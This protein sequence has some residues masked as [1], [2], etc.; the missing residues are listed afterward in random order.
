[1]AQYY[2]VLKKAIGALSPSTSDARRGVYEK[3]R[4]ALVGQL[5]A[6][7]P[8]LSTSEI[9]RQ[10][11]ELEEAI[12]KVEREALAVPIQVVPSPP[13]PAPMDFEDE[14]PHTP[15]EEPVEIEEVEPV[16]PPGRMA[17]RSAAEEHDAFTVAP[18]RP[19][20]RDL[21]EDEGAVETPAEPPRVVLRQA[22]GFDQPGARAEQAAAAPRESR[23]ESAMNWRPLAEAAVPDADSPE[24]AEVV[25]E[26][27]VPTVLRPDRGR[28]QEHVEDA[29]VEAVHAERRRSRIPAIILSL[30]VIGTL[31]A[32]GYI[33]WSQGLIAD[34]IG[35]F[36]SDGGTPGVQVAATDPTKAEDRVTPGGVSPGQAPPANVRV[37]DP[38]APG[39]AAAPASPSGA[40]APQAAPAPEVDVALANP[41]SPPLAPN[42]AGATPPVAQRAM[43]IDEVPGGTPAVKTG[44]VTWSYA[45]AGPDGPT[46]TAEV[47]VPNANVKFRVLLHENTFTDLPANLLIE[48]QVEG[49]ANLPGGGIQAVLSPAMKGSP[50]SLGTPLRGGRDVA[51]TDNLFWVALLNDASFQTENLQLLGGQGWMDIPLVYASGGRAVLTLELGPP[52]EG[53]VDQAIVAWAQ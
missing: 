38:V 1:M 49:S 42:P 47:S 21:V 50:Q 3:A 19:Y 20:E 51:V 44:T 11:L 30:F 28:H 26:E 24:D 53:A 9:S 4:N 52:G 23:Q 14:E 27:P 31:A 5:K 43:L 32:I 46:V 10:R 12:R 39:A 29:D 37:I 18:A 40:V 13:S 2:A 45:T 25:A 6:I 17:P 7:Q 15:A 36:R 48:V 41:P 33:T 34:L 16:M 8:P 35:A 22:F